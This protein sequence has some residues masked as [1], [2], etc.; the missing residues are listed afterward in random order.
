MVVV[1]LRALRVAALAFTPRPPAGGR[2]VCSLAPMVTIPQRAERVTEDPQ[3]FP[4]VRCPSASR[5]VNGL[6]EGAVLT[7]VVQR[8]LNLNYM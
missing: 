5:V 3:L 8:Q 1:A 2:R 6:Y 4:S 7:A